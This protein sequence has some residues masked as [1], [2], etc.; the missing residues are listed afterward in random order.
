VNELIILLTGFIQNWFR[1][2]PGQYHKHADNGP[3]FQ[4]TKDP[5]FFQP[6]SSIHVIS[7]LHWVRYW[8]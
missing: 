3:H 7:S 6:G 5:T 1:A 4:D 2:L 8:V